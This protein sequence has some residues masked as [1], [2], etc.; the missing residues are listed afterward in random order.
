MTKPF[1]G[2][3]YGET[4][5]RGIDTLINEFKEHFNNPDSVFYD[6][7]SGK[8]DMVIYIASNTPVKKACG[9]E[10]HKERFNMAQEKL[11][12]LSLDNVS[13]LNEDF[14]ESDISDA[15][16][17]YIDNLLIPDDV[18]TQLWE[19]IPDGALVIS[20]LKLKEK[21]SIKY[22]STKKPIRRSYANLKSLYTIK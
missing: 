8:G 7:G 10:L 3:T 21:D 22:R 11:N 5:L 14:L 17:I 1:K 6:L 20:T 15:T 18:Q 12:K 13:F 19:N 9:I 16:I 4:T 2:S